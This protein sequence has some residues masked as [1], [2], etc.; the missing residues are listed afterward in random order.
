MCPIN[1]Q[2]PGL[3]TVNNDFK[4]IDNLIAT[5]CFNHLQSSIAIFLKLFLPLGTSAAE[6]AK[7]LILIK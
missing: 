6:L 2:D 3:D 1:L 5:S 7:S 4:L